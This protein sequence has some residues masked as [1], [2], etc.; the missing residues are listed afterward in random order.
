[1]AT[2]QYAGD[3]VGDGPEQVDVVGARVG[4][5]IVAGLGFLLGAVS[6]GVLWMLYP[7][8]RGVQWPMPTAGVSSVVL[9]IAGYV[10]IRRRIGPLVA[11]WFVLGYLVA[12]LVMVAALTGDQMLSFVREQIDQT[13]V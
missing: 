10:T 12:L 3:V 13:R 2:E 6:I 4:L 1:M 5:A 7:P 9:L 8:A 11:D